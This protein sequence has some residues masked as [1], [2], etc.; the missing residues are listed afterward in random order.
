[1]LFLFLRCVWRILKYAVYSCTVFGESR[2]D[3]CRWDYEG[4]LPRQSEG[5]TPVL[6]S[7]SAVVVARFPSKVGT[8]RMPVFPCTPYAR[9]L[10][11]PISVQAPSHTPLKLTKTNYLAF[12]ALFLAGFFARN[13]PIASD[14]G[15]RML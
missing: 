7:K 1:M 12:R 10:T 2:G 4:N 9:R 13:I 6:I 15:A 3:L 11:A 5:E 14:I 8:E